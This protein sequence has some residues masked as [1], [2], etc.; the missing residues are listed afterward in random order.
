MAWNRGEGMEVPAMGLSAHEQRILESIEERLADSDPKLASLL[1][2]FGRLAAAEAMPPREETRTGRRWPAR[3]PRRGGQYQRHDGT[4]SS[5]SRSGQRLRWRLAFP[6]LWLAISLSL[7][8]L[9][10]TLSRGGK[11]AAGTCTVWT[12]T[13]AVR[14]QQVSP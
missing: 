5:P 8:A 9:A 1:G 6:V 12:P 3:R 14:V 11:G 2:T 13:C 4:H 10:L 7:M